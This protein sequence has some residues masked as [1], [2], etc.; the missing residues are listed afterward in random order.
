MFANDEEEEDQTI[1]K[2][3]IP[4]HKI[5]H[6]DLEGSKKDIPGILNT[7]ERLYTNSNLGDKKD[8]VKVNLENK[9]LECMN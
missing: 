3:K 1:K 2:I 9:I 5:I 8:V 6:I 4:K 7:D